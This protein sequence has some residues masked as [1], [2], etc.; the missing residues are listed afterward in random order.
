MRALCVT[1]ALGVAHAPGRASTLYR[2][3][4]T[5]CT[6]IPYTFEHAEYGELYRGGYLFSGTLGTYPEGGYLTAVPWV[7]KSV[8]GR[9]AVRP[10]RLYYRLLFYRL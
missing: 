10:D 4:S 1:C 6:F 5:S 9:G 3:V 8:G 2:G 7:G